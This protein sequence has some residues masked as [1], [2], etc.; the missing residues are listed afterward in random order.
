MQIGIYIAGYRLDLFDDEPINFVG[1]ATDLNDIGKVYMDFSQSFSV[2]A[3]RIN[4]YVFQHYYESD[5]DGTFNANIRIPGLI[6]VGTMP[7][8]SGKIQLESVKLKDREPISYKITFYSDLKNLQDKFGDDKLSS[9]SGTS[10]SVYDH[11]YNAADIAKGLNSPLWMNGEIIYPLISSERPWR[12]GTGDLNDIYTDAGAIVYNELKPAVRAIRII[13]AI[14]QRYDISFTR[15]FFGKAAFQDLYMWLSKGQGK[16]RALG[17]P[18]RADFTSSVDMSATTSTL[19]LTTDTLTFTQ[20]AGATNR[21]YVIFTVDPLNGYDDIEYKIDVEVNGVISQTLTGED[22][23]GTKS[24]TFQPPLKPTPQ[25][26]NVRFFVT[27]TSRL[28]FNPGLTILR[29]QP[30]F[31]NPYT[32]STASGAPQIADGTVIITD[33]MPDI[34]VKDW[35]GGIIKMFNL[36]IRPDGFDSFYVDTMDSYYAAGDIFDITDYTDIT[37][38]EVS[39][40]VL[41]KEINFKYNKGESILPARF[42]DTFGGGETGY[43]DLKAVY[44]I[45]SGETL[46][47]EV[48]FDNMLFERLTVNDPNASATTVSNIV[49]GSAFNVDLKSVAVKPIFFYNNGILELETPF[50]FNGNNTT[51]PYPTIPRVYNISNENDVELDQITNTINFNAEVS[52]YLYTEIESSLYANYWD[53][54]VS[55]IYNQKQRKYSYTAYLPV[56]IVNNFSINDRLNINDKQY[57]INDY[58]IDLTTGKGQLNLYNNYYDEPFEKVIEGVSVS[59]IYMN[60]GKKHYDITISTTGDWTATRTVL[61]GSSSSWVNLSQS[62][63]NG[64]TTVTVSLAHNAGTGLG[65]TS[66]RAVRIDWVT[67]GNTYT[68]TI[69]QEGITYS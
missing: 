45:D 33:Q 27:A 55:N 11:S 40:P 29:R 39:R 15:D 54:Y 17:T 51:T 24:V 48:P 1:K 5:I 3:S 37:D 7:F 62:S 23:K 58:K 22:I 2:P 66:T 16:L 43:G 34:K 28:I 32:R 4:N 44:P 20:N 69:T 10:L 47:I 59:N 8:R 19:N 6:E 18:V 57:R 36:V 21:Y 9:L 38:I 42:R 68:T 41:N 53:R 46:K 14:E 50:K 61:I 25:T 49:T 63:G 13:E 12:I 26:Y 65:N 35:L 64:T 30:V 60:A 52:P 67:N 56:N 31:G